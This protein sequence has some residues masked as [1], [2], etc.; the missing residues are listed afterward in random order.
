MMWCVLCKD[1]GKESIYYGDTG[2]NSYSRGKKHLEDFAAQLSSHCMT[3]HLRVHHPDVPT[4]AS[5]FRMNPLRAVRK[6][7]D[8]QITEALNIANS[9]VDIL[10][11]SGTEWRSG[12]LS[13]ASVTRPERWYGIVFVW[14]CGSRTNLWDE[15]NK[16]N[17]CFYANLSNFIQ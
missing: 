12:H 4:D 2:K 6:P 1:T 8:R 5:N 7:L 3:I 13:R 10:L 16:W 17:I 9:D 15:E 11:N 14:L